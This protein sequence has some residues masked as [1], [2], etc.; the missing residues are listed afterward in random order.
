MLLSSEIFSVDTVSIKPVSDAFQTGDLLMLTKP[1]SV[2]DIVMGW[3]DFPVN[4]F[5]MVFCAIDIILFLN[6]FVSILPYIV[7]GVFNLKKIISLEDSVRLARDRGIAAFISTLIMILAV[8]RYNIYNPEYFN[9]IPT[10]FH[11]L[12]IVG[13]GLLFFML[14]CLMIFICTPGHISSGK[15]KIANKA[16]FNFIIYTAGVVVGIVALG[17]L[18]NISPII[19]K[20]LIIIQ[21][22]ISYIIFIVRKVQIIEKDSGYIIAILYLCGVEI[23]PAILL[24]VSGVVL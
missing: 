14:R 1:V 23:L 7:G 4:R 6:R 9:F 19:I 18:F 12:G 5:F 13:I 16:I 21:I 24:V 20:N 17:H 8:S 11:I 15:Y 22:V 2:S 3:G 10:S